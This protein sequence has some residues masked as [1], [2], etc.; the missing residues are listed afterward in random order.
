[1]ICA[2]ALSGAGSAVTCYGGKTKEDERK[3]AGANK[4]AHYTHNPYNGVVCNDIIMATGVFSSKELWR[5][6]KCKYTTTS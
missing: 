1:M 3:A 6:S 4:C 2:E 5:L